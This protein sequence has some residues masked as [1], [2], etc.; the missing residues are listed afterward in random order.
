VTE[1]SVRE[2]LESYCDAFTRNDCEAWVAHFA[3]DAEFE[4]PVGTPRRRGRA[5]L[6][7]FF[8]TTH[9]RYD[10]VSL[11][12]GSPIIVA[13]QE[14]AFRITGHPVIAG[15]RARHRDHQRH[16]LRRGRDDQN[17]A[18]LPERPIEGAGRRGRPVSAILCRLSPATFLLLRLA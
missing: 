9:G 18:G 4:D 7:E 8:R 11:V 6:A 10:S 17:D 5:E 2:T 15:E 1:E 3:E 13:G 12:L 16:A 14:V